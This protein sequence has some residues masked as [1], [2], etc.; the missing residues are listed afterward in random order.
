MDVK[1]D[2]ISIWMT[3]EYLMPRAIME[4][5]KN[6]NLLRQINNDPDF[7]KKRAFVRMV[8]TVLGANKK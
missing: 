1:D 7:F 2:E 4:K 5:W 6:L 8:N 3:T